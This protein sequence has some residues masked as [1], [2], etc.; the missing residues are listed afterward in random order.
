[1]GAHAFTLP[2]TQLELTSAE[3]SAFDWVQCMPWSSAVCLRAVHEDRAKGANG[4][5]V[6][7]ADVELGASTLFAVVQNALG[8][9]REF[10]Y[11]ETAERSLIELWTLQQ[12]AV[13]AVVAVCPGARGTAKALQMRASS[14]EPLTVCVGDLRPK[15]LPDLRDVLDPDGEFEEYKIPTIAW[16]NR[17]S[18]CMTVCLDSTGMRRPDFRKW[19]EDCASK[20]TWR[21]QAHLAN[22]ATNW[23]GTGSHLAWSGGRRIRVWPRS[24]SSCGKPFRSAQ[25]RR[26]RCYDCWPGQ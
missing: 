11:G 3:K 10:G 12:L 20:T 17:G 2:L 6:A 26:R 22:I 14:G 5:T 21:E 18:G 23:K 25:A 4:F 7:A 19:C 8:L 15:R 13:E 9:M 24:C 1:M 16:N